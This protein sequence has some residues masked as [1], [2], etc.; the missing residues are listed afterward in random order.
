M[1]AGSQTIPKRIKTVVPILPRWAYAD[2][3]GSIGQRLRGT[4]DDLGEPEESTTLSFQSIMKY[5]DDVPSRMDGTED[6]ILEVTLRR[7]QS[8]SRP[9]SSQIGW[10]H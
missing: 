1:I 5:D 6:T 8:R 9:A 10:S 7:R 3:L 2:A 4:R